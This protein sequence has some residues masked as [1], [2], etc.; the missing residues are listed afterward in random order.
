MSQ[1][2]HGPISGS[3]QFQHLCAHFEQAGG[4]ATALQTIAW[5][6]SAHP[7]LIAHATIFSNLLEL[8]Q[9]EVFSQDSLEWASAWRDEVPSWRDALQKIEAIEPV[10]RADTCLEPMFRAPRHAKDHPLLRHGVTRHPITAALFNTSECGTATATE[11][12]AR[13]GY[14][15]ARA[16]VVA[17]YAEARSR[18]A[19][20]LVD[21]LGH[22]GVK[23][24]EPVPL[25]AGPVGLALREF[26]LAR[27]APL[28]CQLPVTASTVQY[29]YT[30]SRLQPDFSGLP[31]NLRADASRYFNDLQ[32]YFAALPAVLGSSQLTARTR[33]AGEIE[34]GAGGHALRS[35]WVNWTGAVQRELDL[36]WEEDA[37]PITLLTVP[38]IDEV[39]AKDEEVEGECPGQTR[40]SALA[41]YHPTKV[42]VPAACLR[43]RD[44]AVE[45]RGQGLP[46][47]MDVATAGERARALQIAQDHIDHYLSGRP[48]NQS[49][50]HL[51]AVGG[52]L[53]KA[54]ALYGWSTDS[55]AGIAVRPIEQLDAQ[56]VDSLAFIQQGQITLLATRQDVGSAVW[57]AVAFLVP[58]LCPS[59][60]TRLADD[61]VAAGRLR[62]TAFL[63]SDV[64]GLGRDLLSIAD[65]QGRLLDDSVT[66]RALGVENKTARTIAKSCLGEA[67]DPINEDVRANLTAARLTASIRLAIAHV[68][69]DLVPA[70][71]ISH[72]QS[73]GSE[74]RLYY[75][76]VR[77]AR[78]AEWHRLALASI[79]GD[80]PSSARSMVSVVLEGNG[81]RSA[82]TPPR[83][84]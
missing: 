64:G 47:S 66:R 32:R 22:S 82:I 29:A 49:K 20:G 15:L 52:I 75:T 71:M 36:D 42:Q 3:A 37:L 11:L 83:F 74:A 45:L 10:L 78:L 60:Q 16:H 57:R 17:M 55:T 77:A 59:Y 34:D 25:G 48:T 18:A 24:F 26:S 58:G 80:T 68:S 67:A 9:T 31:T 27:Y 19:R 41:T 54:M 6:I 72:D 13:Q 61:T 73:R 5:K 12:S 44:L 2:A 63:L 14:Q 79:D 69:K 62:Q 40:D 23:E 84:H 30:L 76:Q 50:A 1:V 81:F 70:W 4:S 38:P 33:G 56:L 65:K 35:G 46:W 51:A 39:D 43:R 21:F 7:E 8:L 53:I 28:I